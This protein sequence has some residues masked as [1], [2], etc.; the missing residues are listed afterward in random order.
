MPLGVEEIPAV[1]ILVE[2][3]LGA[4]LLAEALRAFF[5]LTSRR[6]H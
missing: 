1:A 4:E 3:T 6:Q 2:T 5:L